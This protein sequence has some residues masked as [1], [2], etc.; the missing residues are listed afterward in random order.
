[1]ITGG[2][3]SD[4][5]FLFE[6][7]GAARRAPAGL[8]RSFAS[9][10]DTLMSEQLRVLIVEDSKE[11]AFFLL[12][13]LEHSIDYEVVS[14]RV[15]TPEAFAAALDGGDWDV[16][17]CDYFVPGFGALAALALLREKDLDLPF[18]I[19]SGLVGEDV[20]VAAMRAGAHDYIMKSNLARLAP[21]IEREVR[22]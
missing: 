9:G 7:S 13:E 20:A 14:E 17:V 2:S 21:A 12:R 5:M 19:V 22:E 3:G 15:E 1:M 8:L 11:D 6:E 16:I 4:Y 18:I 10:W